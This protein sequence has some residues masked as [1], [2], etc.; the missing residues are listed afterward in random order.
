MASSIENF[1]ARL[2]GEAGVVRAVAMCG[3]TPSLVETTRLGSRAGLGPLR[4]ADS[5]ARHYMRLGR[6]NERRILSA[7]WSGGCRPADSGGVAAR[8]HAEDSVDLPPDLLLEVAGQ[9]E[10]CLDDLPLRADQV[11]RGNDRNIAVGLR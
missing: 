9:A 2:F 6:R 5:S 3:M 1:S 4:A 8:R 10:E 7:A 11:R